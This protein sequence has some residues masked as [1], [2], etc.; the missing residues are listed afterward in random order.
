MA[1]SRYLSYEF[2]ALSL[3]NYQSLNGARIIDVGDPINLTDAVNK[4]YVD[5]SI[6]GSNLAPGVGISIVNNNINVVSSQTQITALGT[7]QT[8][9]WNANTIQIPYGGKWYME[10]TTQ[11]LK[12][13]N[14]SFIKNKI[15]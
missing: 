5:N 1:N 15:S 7:I 10:Y 3:Q 12:T 6:Q 9:T 14:K 13:F 2:G 11:L 4:G 8:G